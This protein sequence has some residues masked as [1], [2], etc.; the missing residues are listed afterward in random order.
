[1]RR[2][3]AVL[4]FVALLPGGPAAA[5][6]RLVFSLPS[7]VAEIPFQLFGNHIYVRGRV[8]D[9]DSLWIV[10]DTGASTASISDSKAKALGLAIAPGG[11]SRGAGGTVESGIVS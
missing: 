11:T 8:G 3:L 4:A 9:S 10:F 2:P 5:D 7:G 6:P 1:M